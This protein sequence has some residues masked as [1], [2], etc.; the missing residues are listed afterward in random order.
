MYRRTFVAVASALLVV[1]DILRA[2]QP[3]K[4]WLI[5]VLASAPGDSPLFKAFREGL[6]ELGYVE[7][8]NV[9]FEYRFAAGQNDL[10]AGLAAELVRDKVDLILTDGNAAVHAAKKATSTIPIV[11]GTSGDPISSGAV[12]TLSH[13]GGNVTGL[14]LLGVE[15]AGKKLELIGGIVPNMTAVGLLVNPTNPQATPLRRETEVAARSQGL[16]LVSTPAATPK[17]LAQAFEAAAKARVGAMITMPDAMFW[18]SRESLV[19][20]AAK[21]RLPT[22]YAEREFVESGGLM[23]YGPSVPKNFHRA[24]TFVDKIFKGAN[25]ASLPVE[26]PTGV[27]LV[28]NFKT[29]KALG[30]TI[31][32][33]VLLRADE[34]IQ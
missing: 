16:R 31:P 12:T 29:A 26:Q 3:A 34:V 1:A 17:E 20:L 18:N 9:R 10:L 23:S 19:E 27:E 22:I 21:V 14:T 33:T 6:R 11:M 13:P 30:I 25:P 32:Q 8:Q 5:G 15:L 2:Q 28:I 4:V 24:A 7:G